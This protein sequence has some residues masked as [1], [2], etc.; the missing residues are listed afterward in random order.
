MENLKQKEF[1][2]VPTIVNA[3]ESHMALVFLLDTSGSMSG[4]P[5]RALNDG[6]NRFKEEVSKDKQT[7]DILDVAIIEFNSN[8]RVVQ[9]FV[10]IE[11]MDHVNLDVIGSTKM[12]P[13]IREALKMVDD[14]SRFYRRSGAEPYKPWIILISDGAPDSDDDIT[15]VAKEIKAMEEAGK[16]SFRSLGVEGYD[17]KTLHTLSGLKVMKLEG[18]D[19]SSFFDWVN[20]SM[21]SVSQSSPGEKAKAIDLSGNVS[22]DRNTDWD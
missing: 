11:Y 6:L 8:H 5:I 3:S 15:I 22:V 10:P 13:A 2:E 14:R 9:E 19:F 20:K 12:S 18:T 7:R 21:R 16:V 4:D 17:P 1:N